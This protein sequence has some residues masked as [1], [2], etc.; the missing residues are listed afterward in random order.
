MGAPPEVLDDISQRRYRHPSAIS[1]QW[2]TRR[3][4]LTLTYLK[5]AIE[6]I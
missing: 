5:P 6:Q 4:D 3:A 2:A 1:E